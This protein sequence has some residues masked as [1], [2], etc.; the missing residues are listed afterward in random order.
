MPKDVNR[1]LLL[2]D[3]RT[4]AP[5]A[6]V[7]FSVFDARASYLGYNPVNNLFIISL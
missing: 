4:E 5:D 7:E 6:T 1:N 2:K 3:E